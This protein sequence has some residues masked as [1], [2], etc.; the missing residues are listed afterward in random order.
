MSV[1]DR[2]SAMAD[3][4]ELRDQTLAYVVLRLVLGMNLMMHGVG[5]LLM[6]AGEFA[7]KLVTQFAHS[8][9]P[10]WS[11]WSFGLALP[12]V[13]GLLGV[14]LLVGLRTRATLIAAGT[15][16][17]VLTFGSGLLQDWQAAGTQLIYAAIISGLIALQRFDG[18]SVD[19]LLARD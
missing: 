3:G 6:G 9:L 8:P 15:L 2:E 18:W 13:E 1:M 14:L 11:V 16:M 10:T 19:A 17:L 12:G 5:R 7:E 4:L